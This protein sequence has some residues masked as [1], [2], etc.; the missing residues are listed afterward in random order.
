MASCFSPSRASIC[1]TAASKGRAAPGPLDAL[2]Y[3]ERGV[4]RPG[5]TVHVTTLLR[6]ADG[7]AVSGLPLTLVVERPDGAEDRREVVADQGAGGRVLDVPLLDAA[8]TG[9]WRVKVYAETKRP[10][11]GEVAFL[12]EDYV[13][14]R[15]ELTVET[16]AKQLTAAGAPVSLD[17]RWLYGAPAA[18]LA[19]EGEITVQASSADLPGFAG[20]K[21]GLADEELTPV[22]VPLEN[23]G[24]TD[25]QGKAK[26]E[27][28]RPKLPDTTKA[29][30]ARIALRLRE[31]GG[32]ALERTVTLPVQPIGQR[33]GVKPLFGDRVG[34]GE[35][36]NFDVVLLGEDGRPVAGKNLRWE[37]S[38]LPD[39]VSVVFRGFELGA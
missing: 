2:V 39:A 36:A 32:R 26:V 22:R 20:Y 28:A 3:T 24:R 8:G 7:V 6:D 4:Y 10:P 38:R 34:D 12:V 18:D 9:T 11:V 23:L 37:L 29:L 27:I 31:P 14:E 13:P 5:E 17:G 35:T 21:F 1:R 33:I 16:D 30:E 15:L 25:A 19:I